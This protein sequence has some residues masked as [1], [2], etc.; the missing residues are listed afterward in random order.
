MN[1]ANQGLIF[2]IQRF[3]IHDGSGIRTTVF[4]KGCSLQCFWCHNPEG[5]RPKIEIQLHPEHCIDCDECVR[6]CPQGTRIVQNG[7][8]VLDRALCT[9]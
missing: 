6:L 1:A 7:V 4:L 9:V 3:L 8:R 5:I 2:N